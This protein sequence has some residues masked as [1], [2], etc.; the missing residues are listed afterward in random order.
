MPLASGRLLLLLMHSAKNRQILPNPAPSLA[1][2][3]SLSQKNGNSSLFLA[4]EELLH[5][6]AGGIHFV[7][8]P[9][10]RQTKKGI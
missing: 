1:A 2:I 9:D 5:I 6:D 4:L 7:A 3:A 10:L 8:F